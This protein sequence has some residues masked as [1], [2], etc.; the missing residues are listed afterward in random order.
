M[1]GDR[2]YIDALL[3]LAAEGAA[4]ENATARGDEPESDEP[5]V[6][7]QPEESI[8]LDEIFRDYEVGETPT[9]RG[10]DDR[11]KRIDDVIGTRGSLRDDFDAHFKKL[12]LRYFKPHE[13][14]VMGGS[15]ASGPCKDKNSIPSKYMWPNIVPAIL[16]LDDIRDDLGYAIRPTS[17]YRSPAYNACIGKHS[18]GVAK[19]SQHIQFRA[20]DFQGTQGSP[21]DWATAVER[22]QSKWGLWTRTYSTFVHIDGRFYSSSSSS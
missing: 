9:S 10:D 19:H 20:I 8:D 5:F 14:L 1:R 13:L 12:G 22:V 21:S 17:V 18:S 15:N 4:D 6:D 11:T 3:E 16:A 7:D 2:G